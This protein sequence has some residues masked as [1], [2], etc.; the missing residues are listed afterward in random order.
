MGHPRVRLTVTSPVPVAYLSVRLCDVFPDGTSALAGRGL[1]NLTHRNG[2]DAPVALEPGVPTEVEIELEATSWVFERG[3]RVRLSL[4]GS[5]WPNTWP[6]PSSAPLQIERSSVELVLPVLDGPPVLPAPTLPPTTGKDTHAP[7][8]DGE[9]PHGRLEVR[10]R[11]DAARDARRD[12]LRFRLRGA[13]R[14]E[15]RGAVRGH[16]RRLEGRSGGC[17]GAWADGVPHHLARGRRAHGGDARGASPTQRP[18]TSSSSSSPR[19]SDRS[20][21]KRRFHRE[22]RF[23]RTIARHLA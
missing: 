23:E 5:D 3:H 1:L 19:S 9:Q 6:P 13:V 4:A 18:T 14:R 22:R 20:P 15:R 17:V 8:T 21:G 2:H 7:A 11:S 10:G 16:G 12:E